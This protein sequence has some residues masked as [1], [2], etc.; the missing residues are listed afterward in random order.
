MNNI[1]TV[2]KYGNETNIEKSI[3]NL[4]PY[5]LYPTGTRSRYG[6][7][8]VAER[9]YQNHIW[10]Y[11]SGEV[12]SRN[13]CRLPKVI[14][15]KT[16]P[17]KLIFEHKVLDVFDMPNPWMSS[18][19]FWKSICL[20][21]LLPSRR[22]PLEKHKVD[23]AVPTN[24]S[25]DMG[26]TGGQVFL[27]PLTN[28]GEKVNL[29]RG[30]IPDMILPY[31][32]RYIRAKETHDPDKGTTLDG[33][34]WI[35]SANNTV[36]D[37]FSPEEIIR[38]NLLNPYDWIRGLSPLTPAGLALVDD[39]KSDI[40][41]TESFENDGT[42]AGLLSTENDM[43]N[44]QFEINLKR[45]YSRNGGVG[46]NNRIAMI[47]N[48]LKYQQ[49]GLSQADMQFTEQKRWIFEK[50]AAAYGLNK[51]AYGKYEEIN[52]ATIREGRR[53]LWIDT[54]QPLDQLICNAITTQWIKYVDKGAFLHSDYSRVETLRE[55]YTK[56]AQAAKV[57]VDMG[58]PASLA[59]KI[60]N[61][62][63][64][65]EMIQKYPW[66]DEKPMQRQP[67]QEQGKEKDKP[68]KSATK[69][70]EKMQMSEEERKAQS[71]DYIHKVLDPGEKKWKSTM[72]RFFNSQRNRMQDKVDVW[73]K[74]QKEIP[75][76]I[77]KDIYLKSFW[78]AFNKEYP[79]IYAYQYQI[80]NTEYLSVPFYN[81][82][83]GA[84]MLKTP[85]YQDW[86]TEEAVRA[87]DK[88]NISVIKE[89]IIDPKAFL[90]NPVEENEKLLQLVKPLIVD[91]MRREKNRLNEELGTLI[92]WDV[93]DEN[94]KE[95]IEKRKKDIKEINTTTFKKANKKIGKAIEISIEE[96][97]T[98]Q[99]AAKRIKAAISEVVETRKNAAQ[100]IARTETGMIS[101]A[102]RFEAF[103]VEGVEYH[104][105]LNAADEKIR[106]DHTQKPTG[107]GGE[108][109][110]VGA[111]FPI[112]LMRYPLDPMGSADQIINCR[113]VAIAVEEPE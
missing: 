8:N 11:A 63:I 98:P 93:T 25:D 22:A 3:P 18:I 10:T 111:V 113:C 55:D 110:R 96:N 40:Y 36:I 37:T 23:K 67:I 43:T 101:G 75:K 14:S 91:Q 24:R 2:D 28:S 57:M 34:Q 46:N 30:D 6:G 35:N 88:S 41:N 77:K 60:N 50:F 82:D 15:K 105:W 9:P 78:K 108:V 100:T 5:F 17:D 29:R 112:V 56:R 106:F 102:A 20:G 72:I 59:S 70:A 54:Y 61:I 49:F 53:M 86:D 66:L 12:I 1:I 45:W 104:E 103:H 69:S 62:P 92:E 95:F 109:V 48:G 84:R 99:E 76:N 97:E 42:V 51:I 89:I 47:A 32:D 71:W 26:D 13:V 33:W 64:T 73:E 52:F 4:D 90:L 27:I 80:K 44:D 87:F 7:G 83:E 19:G 94:I 85:K 81:K 31:T 39:I 21:L 38:I 74:K 68:K 79:E 107:V 58:Y 65:E 16:D